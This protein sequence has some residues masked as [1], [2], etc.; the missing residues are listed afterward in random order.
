MFE[1]SLAT[2]K[3]LF[4]ILGVKYAGGL[5]FPGIDEKGA[6]KE[7]SGALR[8]AYEAGQRLVEGQEQ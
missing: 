6:V 1:P 8:Q 5:F 2:V 3:T 7:R 4:H